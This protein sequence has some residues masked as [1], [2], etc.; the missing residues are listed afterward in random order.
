MSI[1]SS[2]SINIQ[3]HNDLKVF[4]YHIYQIISEMFFCNNSYVTSCN[5]FK[6]KDNNKKYLSCLF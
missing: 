1:N 6:G 2:N 4:D 3:N 5:G